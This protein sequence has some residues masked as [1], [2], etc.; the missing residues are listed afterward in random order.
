MRTEIATLAGGCF[1]GVEELFRSMKGV[2]QTEVGYTGGVTPS[3]TYETVK[4]GTTGHAESIEI[5]FDPEAVSFEEILRY[6]FQLHDPTTENRQ[7]NDRGSQYRS[8]IFYHSDAQKAV[9]D[10]VIAAV[11]ASGQWGGK[12]VTQVVSAS[13]FYSAEAYH[14]DYLQKNPGGYTCHWVRPHRF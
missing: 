3:P 2:I 7:G 6:F 9:A 5:T 10:K 1:W 4:T 8:A 12:V 11:N 13:R 14:Q